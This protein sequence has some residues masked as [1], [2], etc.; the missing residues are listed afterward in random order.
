MASH[1]PEC[2]DREARIQ[3][4]LREIEREL[5]QGLPEPDQT[6]DRIEQQVVEI[7]RKVRELLERET[8]DAAGQGY[9]GPRALCA[10]GE[11][12]RFVAFYRRTVVTLHGEPALTR[13]YY[14]CRA[15][16]KGFCP[17]DQRLQLG[18]DPHSAGVRALAARY[19]SYLSER[20]AASELAAA[21]GVRISARSVHREAV[22]TALGGNGD[23]PPV[24]PQFYHSVR[25]LLRSRRRGL[26]CEEALGMPEVPIGDGFL[27]YYFDNRPFGGPRIRP[28]RLELDPDNDLLT[29]E[30]TG[31]DI[32]S[33]A[34]SGGFLARPV[35]GDYSITVKL[36]EKPQA[37]YSGSGEN[38]IKVGPMIRDHV[39]LGSRYATL[40]ATSGRGVL[41]ERRTAFQWERRASSARS[42]SGAEGDMAA[43][44][45]GTT[46]PLWLRLT[47][48]GAVIT[49][50]QSSDGIQFI[51]TGSEQIP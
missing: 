15:C 43:D 10:C 9:L 14:H 20:E 28:A 18:R 26:K 11:Q 33:F 29:I 22:G 39:F 35:T 46:Y 19:A 27:L 36:L 34:D 21:A 23:R 42:Y 44:D 1:D 37:L 45:A 5:R 13:A 40:A 12:A 3:R 32:W 6:L 24:G 50:S 7:G 17:L 38:N 25:A 8:L 31:Q 51:Q 30:A 49:A 47:K 4:L 2:P 16:R 41:W 48:L